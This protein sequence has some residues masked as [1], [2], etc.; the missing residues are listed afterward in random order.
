MNSS[1][2][3]ENLSHIGT[4]L[5]FASKPLQLKG[6]WLEAVRVIGSD[7]NYPLTA[8]RAAPVGLDRKAFRFSAKRFTVKMAP[9]LHKGMSVNNGSA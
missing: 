2:R 3:L 8:D 1:F 6:L 5:P 4:T 7:G 9:S